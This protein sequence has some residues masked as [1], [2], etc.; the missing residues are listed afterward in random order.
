MRVVSLRAQN[1]LQV[2]LSGKPGSRLTVAVLGGAKVL[3]AD[4]GTVTAL[5]GRLKVTIAPNGLSGSGAL[6]AIASVQPLPWSDPNSSTIGVPYDIRLVGGDLVSPALIRFSPPDVDNDGLID[7]SSVPLRFGS[8]LSY[9]PSQDSWTEPLQWFDPATNIL[10]VQA[11]H[12]SI[13]WYVGMSTWGGL[14]RQLLWDVDVSEPRAFLSATDL[15]N[16][17]EF[18]FSLWE[19]ETR[20]A[21]L[22]YRRALPGETPNVV[23]GFTD[24]IGAIAPDGAGTIAKT[25]YGKSPRR[26]NLNVNQLNWPLRSYLTDVLTHELGHVI[27]LNHPCNPFADCEEPPIMAPFTNF[28]ADLRLYQDDIDQVR[29]RYPL[30]S[31][32]YDFSYR[33]ASGDIVTGSF[34]GT[35]S[36]NLIT[37]LTSISVFINGIPFRGNGHVYNLG[38]VYN[39]QLPGIPGSAVASF[40]GTAN[41]FSFYD[42]DPTGPY[43]PNGRVFASNPY[44]GGSTTYAYLRKDLT[45]VFEGDGCSCST[46]PY[47]PNSWRVTAR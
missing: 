36:G 31:R 1:A 8:L 20:A 41:A 22:T 7:G 18:G 26:V 27:G 23:V 11:T 3:G 29:A 16:E 44:F 43:D 40:D 47:A 9:E 39:Q 25:S 12:F 28:L 15:A 42:Y 35:P 17:V 13:W 45:S 46:A 24:Q 10:S 38:W 37:R 6:L 30:V 2:R 19:A 33:F 5:D 32:V 14:P 34:T 21:G 4:G